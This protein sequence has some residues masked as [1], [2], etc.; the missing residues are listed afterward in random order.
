MRS[1]I[2]GMASTVLAFGLMG[3]TNPSTSQAQTPNPQVVQTETAPAKQSADNNATDKDVKAAPA[4]REKSAQNSIV[5][6]YSRT[7]E[8]YSV[9]NSV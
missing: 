6:Y 8:N 3:C 7:G 9:G 5:V 4:N 2:I 1:L